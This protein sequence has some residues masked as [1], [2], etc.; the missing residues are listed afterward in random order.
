MPLVL[1][2]VADRFTRVPGIPLS[3]DLRGITPDR[4]AARPVADIAR[5]P[6]EADGDRCRLGD[7]CDVHGSTDDG[8]IECRGD[9]SRVH[10]IGAGM[11]WGEMFVEGDAGRH[12]G[13]A[14]TGGR[15]SIGG[16]AGDWAGAELGGGTVHVGGDAGDNLAGGLPGSEHGMRGGM[17][18]V[19][20]R[21]GALVG[22]RMRRGIVAV[23]G[24]C[25]PAAAFEL[26]AGTVFVIGRIAPH[27]GLGMRRGSLVAA[28]SAPD[29]PPL[30]SRGAL[31]LPP[32]LPFLAAGLRR[33]GFASI[34]RIDDAFGRP[35]QQWHGDPLAGGRG[36]ILHAVGPNT[37][38][39]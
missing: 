18:I 1:D 12:A 8:R 2:R 32:F 6:V 4:G 31:W 9:F 24:G 5:I 27:A 23:G 26:R 25:G 39:S 13:E 35:W 33:A 30:F 29:I 14:M 16:D 21:A 3:I 37:A 28:S 10:W 20:G 17:V 15:L 19:E 34:G 36:E 22:A 11:Q 7:V 38:V